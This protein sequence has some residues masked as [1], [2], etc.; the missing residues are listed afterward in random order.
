MAISRTSFRRGQSG[1]PGGRPKGSRTLAFSLREIVAEAITAPGM[2]EKI[3]AALQQVATNRKTVLA[4]LELAGRL[5]RELGPA[6]DDHSAERVTIVFQSN[7][8]PMKLRAAASC[9]LPVQ[10]AGND[11]A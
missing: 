6:S 2:R 10:T 11:D 8:G 5:N 1:N 9:A 3:I 7:V 4:F